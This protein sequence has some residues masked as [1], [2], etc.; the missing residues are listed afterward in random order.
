MRHKYGTGKLFLRVREVITSPGRCNHYSYLRRRDPSR[1]GKFQDIYIGK[2]ILSEEE[3]DGINR[4][5]GLQ[6][7]PDEIKAL[8]HQCVTGQRTSANS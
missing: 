4:Q 5:V 7:I 3:M 2:V 1:P 6:T 8:V